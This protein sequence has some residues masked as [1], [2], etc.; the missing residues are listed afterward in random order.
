M[1]VHFFEKCP[2]LNASSLLK[3]LFKSEGRAWAASGG[4]VASV[5]KIV[6]GLLLLHIYEIFAAVYNRVSRPNVNVLKS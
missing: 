4:P 6:I 2:S 3:C 5:S 1:S